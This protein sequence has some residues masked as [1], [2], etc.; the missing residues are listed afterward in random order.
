MRKITIKEK[1]DVGNV[2]TVVHTYELDEE[3]DD[4]YYSKFGK[5]ISLSFGNCSHELNLKF[6]GKVT[7]IIIED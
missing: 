1:I 4:I 3:L 7:A 6:N 5:E 2:V